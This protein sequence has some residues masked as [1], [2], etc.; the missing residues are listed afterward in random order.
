MVIAP[1]Q[2]GGFSPLPLAIMTPFMAYQAG[3]M[4]YAFGFQ[5]EKGKRKLSSM[6]N[7]TFNNLSPEQEQAIYSHQHDINIKAFIN[8]I[9]KTEQIQD[10][11]LKEMLALEKSK[12]SMNIE[13]FKYTVNVLALEANTG[14]EGFFNLLTGK[15]QNITVNVDNTH[16]A[17]VPSIETGTQGVPKNPNKTLVQ[18]TSTGR[19]VET[20]HELEQKR[21]EKMGN[22][23][24]NINPQNMRTSGLYNQQVQN[25]AW[26]LISTQ[27]GLKNV[28]NAMLIRV[29]T[30][31]TF[32]EYRIIFL[33]TGKTTVYAGQGRP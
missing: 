2:I 21:R 29:A 20:E 13:L 4:A 3:T 24:R 19:R 10:F 15:E 25:S 6:S 30:N 16:G 7:E 23:I 11:I 17:T 26:T 12:L 33:K 28:L 31:V 32:K 18:P 9:P 27:R 8:A 14:I 1:P 22:L 5:Y